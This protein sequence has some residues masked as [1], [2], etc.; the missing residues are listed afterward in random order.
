M[1]ASMAG[2]PANAAT[3]TIAIY[4]GPRKCSEENTHANT[5]PTLAAANC[6]EPR[7]AHVETQW[8]MCSR[9]TNRRKK[10]TKLLSELFFGMHR[11]YLVFIFLPIVAVALDILFSTRKIYFRPNLQAFSVFH[12]L[13]HFISLCVPHV[14]KIISWRENKM[15]LKHSCMQ[16][17]SLSH[18]VAPL[19]LIKS[20][21][22]VFRVCVCLRLFYVRF[23]GECNLCNLSLSLSPFWAKIVETRMSRVQSRI[24]GESTKSI[25]FSCNATASQNKPQT[26]WLNRRNRMTDSYLRRDNLSHHLLFESNAGSW[27]HVGIEVETNELI[28][29]KMMR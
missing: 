26:H 25:S 19:S 28:E 5:I 16:Y 1:L 13:M 12:R 24:R 6:P 7:W 10:F 9:P 4:C 22:V 8:L 2:R 23:V 11:Y 15:R 18:S 29:Y 20:T 14:W 3:T 17:L 21:V 27:A